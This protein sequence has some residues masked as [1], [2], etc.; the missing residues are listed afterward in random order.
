MIACAC[1]VFPRLPHHFHAAHTKFGG[2]NHQHGGGNGYGN[3]TPKPFHRHAGQIKQAQKDGENHQR[4]TQIARKGN[5]RDAHSDGDAHHQHATKIVQHIHA[6]FEKA[7]HIHN[8]DEFKQFAGL[9]FEAKRGGQP[10]ARAIDH[11]ARKRDKYHH[12]QREQQKIGCPALPSPHRHAHQPK[13]NSQPEQ[14]KLGLLDEK[15]GAVIVV[16]KPCLRARGGIH[17]H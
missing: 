16:V 5:Q 10:A 8:G 6:A 17:H 4:R 7:R 1:G 15:E 13:R 11:F 9:D 12:K 14:G 3:S 2:D